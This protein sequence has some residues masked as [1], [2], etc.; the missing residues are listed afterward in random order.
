LTF[1][2][3]A[4]KEAEFKLRESR[5]VVQALKA[6]GEDRITSKIISEIRSQFEPALRKRILNDTKTATG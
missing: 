5:L 1:Q 4:L 3:T 6:F 2:H